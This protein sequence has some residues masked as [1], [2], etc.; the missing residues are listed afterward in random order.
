MKYLTSIIVVNMAF[1]A[2]TEI[3]VDSAPSI[4][5]R[6]IY[7]EQMGN[8]P[9]IQEY[10]KEYERTGD[11]DKYHNRIRSYVHEQVTNNGVN[12]ENAQKLLRDMG[13]SKRETLRTRLIK[14]DDKRRPFHLDLIFDVLIPFVL[15][16]GG[17]AV[18]LNNWCKPCI[19]RSK[20]LIHSSLVGFFAVIA[21]LASQYFKNRK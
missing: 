16:T 2:K 15:T 4:G 21:C 13:V 6:P 3:I 10:W 17:T 9:Q 20:L 19:E 18:V 1:R 14:K 5:G 11:V 8:I 7:N 12:L